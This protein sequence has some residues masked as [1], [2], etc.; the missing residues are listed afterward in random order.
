M[1][2]EPSWRQRYDSSG[3]VV[4]DFIGIYHMDM[5]D[6]ILYSDIVKDH[7]NWDLIGMYMPCMY[8]YVCPD[9]G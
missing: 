7:L 2:Q 1:E 4:G 8:D 5:G 9:L 3:R 6:F